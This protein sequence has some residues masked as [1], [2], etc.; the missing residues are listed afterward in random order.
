MRS[1]HP[2]D[3][4]TCHRSGS[5]RCFLID[6][7]SV[8]YPEFPARSPVRVDLRYSMRYPSNTI[9]MCFVITPIT[10]SSRRRLLNLRRGRILQG[11]FRSQRKHSELDSGMLRVDRSTARKN[12]PSQQE[13]YVS[14]G[15]GALWIGMHHLISIMD[16]S[17]SSQRVLSS[18]RL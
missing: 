13:F 16:K 14:F 11:R 9:H 18:A 3:K 15:L 5:T 6:S 17:G 8:L 2:D 7:A 12:R 10:P 4:A 1:P